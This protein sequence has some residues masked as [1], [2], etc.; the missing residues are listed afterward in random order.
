[1]SVDPPRLEEEGREA[2]PAAVFSENSA[3]IVSEDQ[4]VALDERPRMGMNV[5]AVEG[6][7]APSRKVAQAKPESMRSWS[8][9]SARHVYN[10]SRTRKLPRARRHYPRDEPR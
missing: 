4:G 5:R 6:R 10:W 2:V 1:M 7:A 3:A 9:R 8:S